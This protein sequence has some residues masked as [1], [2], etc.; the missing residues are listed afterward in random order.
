MLA[1]EIRK[2]WATSASGYAAIITSLASIGYEALICVL[3]LEEY[4]EVLN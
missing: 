4:G 3:E 1:D 2:N